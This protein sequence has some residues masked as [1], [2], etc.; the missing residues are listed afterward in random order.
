MCYRGKASSLCRCIASVSF[1]SCSFSSQR[2]CPSQFSLSPRR[3]LVCSNLCFYLYGVLSALPFVLYTFKQPWA[4]FLLI[5]LLWVFTLEITSR[6]QCV[7]AFAAGNKLQVRVNYSF[8]DDQNKPVW[9]QDASSS[10]A[11]SGCLGV[12]CVTEVVFSNPHNL[13]AHRADRYPL[14]AKQW[15]PYISPYVR[16]HLSPCMQTCGCQPDD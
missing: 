13:P 12:T 1:F 15:S 16:M 7:L 3:S 9:G 10:A 8:P 4:I 2:I 14:W 11:R 6:G 5:I